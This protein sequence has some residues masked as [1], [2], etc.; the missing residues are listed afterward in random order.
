V[1]LKHL[2]MSIIFELMALRYGKISRMKAAS[3]VSERSKFENEWKSD[4]IMV[5]NLLVAIGNA[6]MCFC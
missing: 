3:I 4:Q 1:G 5:A 6:Q 2:D